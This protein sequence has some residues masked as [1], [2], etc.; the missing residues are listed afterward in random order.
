M[1]GKRQREALLQVLRESRRGLDTK[2]LAA[3]VTLHPNTVRWH[4]GVLGD[5]GLVEALPEQRR[6][7]GRPSVVYRLTG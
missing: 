3:A 5:A 4:L 7:R 6:G 2:E 1:D